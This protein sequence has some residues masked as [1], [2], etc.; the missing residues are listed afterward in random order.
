MA[1]VTLRLWTQSIARLCKLAAD[2]AAFNFDLSNWSII[3]Q[4]KKLLMPNSDKEILA[5]VD[6]VNLYTAGGFFK[7]HKDTP[8]STAMFGSLVMCLPSSFEGGQLV[9]KHKSGETAYDWSSNSSDGSTIQWAA[10]YSDCT[11]E[12]LPVTEG[13]RVTIT[14]NLFVDSMTLQ[15]HLTSTTT[16]F[17]EELSKAISEPGF[18]SQGGILGFAC[19]HTY[20]RSGQI[21]IQCAVMPTGKL[22]ASCHM[23]KLAREH[24]SSTRIYVFLSKAYCVDSH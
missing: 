6:K 7:A 19:E 21:C 8:R 15:D 20:P 24:V 23:L 16:N 13:V 22:D 12:I 18:M 4:V 2:S 9:I 10:F 5:R 1:K 11:H 14:Y 17:L 3:A